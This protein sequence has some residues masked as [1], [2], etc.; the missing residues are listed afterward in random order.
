MLNRY[1]DKVLCY[2]DDIQGTASIALAGLTTALQIIDAPL[3]EQ[4]ILFLGA[5]SAAIGIAN[6]IV[7]AMQMKGL[8]QDAARSRISMFDIDGLLEPSRTGLSDAQKPYA[9][10]AEPLK[11]LA[12]TIETL[13]PTVLIGVSTKGGAFNQRVVEAMSRVNERPVIFALSNPT[14]KAECSAE[15]A[16]TWSKGKAL[17]AAGV[18]FPDVTLNGT[19]FRPGQANNFYIF[20]AI[21]LATY[22][23]RPRRLTD[24]CFIAA[25]QATADQVGPSLRAKGMLFP[26]QDQVLETEVTTATRVAEFMFDKGLAQVDRPRDIRQWIEA[27]LYTPHY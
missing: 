8:S 11:D 18:Q 2:N 25:A 19:T 12:K 14:D 21:G 6:L 3:T 10:K 27:Q 7:S 24:A 20:P 4:R 17:Y 16:Y 1:R 5:G 13:K 22:A 15:Q 26:T 23:A 9:H